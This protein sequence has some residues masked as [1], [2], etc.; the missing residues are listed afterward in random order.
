[1]MHSWRPWRRRAWPRFKGLEAAFHVKQWLEPDHGP[2]RP[3]SEHMARRVL[4][5]AISAADFK[6]ASEIPLEDE[7]VPKPAAP[8]E[9]AATPLL[10]PLDERARYVRFHRMSERGFVEFA[11]GVGSPDLMTELIMPLAAYREFCKVNQV[12]YL[13]R[14]EEEAMDVDQA[15]WRYGA[16]GVTE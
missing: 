7:A 3:L 16:P 10:A 6:A 14:E 2:P 9:H 8:R 5:G 12:V 15:K 4:Y 11:F 13:T 1:M